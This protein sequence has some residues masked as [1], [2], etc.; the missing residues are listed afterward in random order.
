VRMY[1]IDPD[2]FEGGRKQ[3]IVVGRATLALIEDF[4]AGRWIEH[5]VGKS[6]TRDGTLLIRATNARQGSNA[7]ISIIEWVEKEQA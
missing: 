7:V 1:I 3:N 6:E 5:A 4:T 2:H